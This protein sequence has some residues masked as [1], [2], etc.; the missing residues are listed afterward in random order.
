MP[1]P[2][3]LKVFLIIDK[4]SLIDDFAEAY[5]LEKKDNEI[6]SWG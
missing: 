1:V 5:R 3:S 6:N 2:R 4:S